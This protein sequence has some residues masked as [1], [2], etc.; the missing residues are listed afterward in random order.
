MPWTLF[1]SFLGSL[2]GALGKYFD[3]K[4]QVELQ[5]QANV[6]AIE[7]EK[8]KL[9]AQGMITQGELGQEQLKATSPW[10]KQSI[11]F[12]FLSP[13]VI[14]CYDPVWGKQIFDSLNI[15]PEW[16]IFIVSSISLAIWGIN[17]DKV[18]NIIQARREYKLE[19]LKI[20]R[21]AY[22]EAKRL[23]QGPLTQKEVEEDTRVLDKLDSQ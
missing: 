13:I 21:Q 10:F 16:Y 3:N 14:T 8:S 5:K 19:K 20:N 23:I 9:I 18:Q 4:T 1:F 6:L 12:L 17:S 2:P 22:F 7:Q 15:V 11:F